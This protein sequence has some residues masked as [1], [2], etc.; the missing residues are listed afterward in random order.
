M[1]LFNLKNPFEPIG[2]NVFM[3]LTIEDGKIVNG[4]DAFC[5]QINDIYMEMMV[6]ALAKVSPKYIAYGNRSGSSCSF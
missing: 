3:T 1:P 6:K 4:F 5:A 2:C